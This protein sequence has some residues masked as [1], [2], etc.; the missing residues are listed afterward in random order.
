MVVLGTAHVATGPI[1]A[2]PGVAKKLGKEK[3]QKAKKLQS[4]MAQEGYTEV[5][6]ALLIPYLKTFCPWGLLHSGPVVR[7]AN[8][9]IFELPSSS[10]FPF[11]GQ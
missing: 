4:E 10:F 11:L 5:P 3:L 8:L 2:V 6:Q 7:V 9:V 1:R